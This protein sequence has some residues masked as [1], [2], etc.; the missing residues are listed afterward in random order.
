MAKKCA[1]ANIYTLK[2]HL[3]TNLFC[4]LSISS[5]ILCYVADDTRFG[6]GVIAHS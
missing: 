5:F 6:E 3:Y 4:D 2:N 1:V